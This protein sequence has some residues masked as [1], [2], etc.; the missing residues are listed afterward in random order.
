MF[1]L[2]EGAEIENLL[3]QDRESNEISR[4]ENIIKKISRKELCYS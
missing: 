2:G 1:T 3:E 4:L